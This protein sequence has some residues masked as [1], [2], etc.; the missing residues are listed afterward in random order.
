M[1]HTLVLIGSFALVAALTA[2][3]GGGGNETTQAGATTG[4]GAT[5]GGGSGG[6]GGTGGG[7]APPAAFCEGKTSLRYDPLAGDI[8]A[9][10]DDFFTIDDATT[11][12][13][14]RVHM[15]LGDNVPKP[16]SGPTFE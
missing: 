8:T 2:S 5:G 6:T 16:A 11:A 7:G 12:T 15:I 4:S 14:L 1:R 3:C 9:F 13:G 10:P